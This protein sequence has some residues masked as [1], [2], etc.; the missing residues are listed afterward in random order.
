[1]RK[2][3]LTWIPLI[4]SLCTA[5]IL[6]GCGGTPTSKANSAQAL[7]VKVIKLGQTGQSALSGKIIPDQENKVVA[8]SAGKVAEVKVNEG[9]VVKKGDVLIQLETDDL[10]Q[11]VKQAESS[12]IAARAKLADTQAGARSQEI[13]GLQSAVHSAE[14]A[15]NQAKAAVDTAK[16][17]FDLAQKNYNRLRNMYDNTNTVT[18][19]DLDRGT[20]EYEKARSAYEQVQAQ[21]Q[22]AAA[23]VSASQSKLDLARSGATDSTVEA[24][25]AEVSRL[26]AGLELA[27]SA[28]TNATI[29]APMD[30][31]IVKRSIQPGEM[32]QPGV[33]LLNL[34]KMDQVQVELS[35]PDTLIG[36][37][38]SG[39]EVDVKVSNLPDK[40]F[41]GKVDFVSPV[42]NTN[43]ST[44]PVKVKVDNLDGQLL[45]GM[46]VEIHLKDAGQSRMEIP[47]SAIV[48]KENKTLI[49]IVEN[50]TAKAVEITLEEKNQDWVYLKDGTNV[51]AGQQ[52]I[53]NPT[54]AI[55]DGSTVKVE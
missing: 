34:V 31:I 36:K 37:M 38:I 24:L 3:Q 28:L 10:E 42:S 11:Q 6:P 44:F 9:S 2:K 35:V 43:T 47:K 26:S 23:Q 16:S 40:I 45:A 8:K 13:Q 33:T 14:A 55:T 39:A 29:T 5:V 50:N 51:K 19:E 12:V 20:F 27:H 25:Q 41:P 46:T 30:G 54:D 18:K 22:A 17:A 7:P 4:L 21:Q 48:K 1:M 52:L 32:A 49:Y 53:I 15:N